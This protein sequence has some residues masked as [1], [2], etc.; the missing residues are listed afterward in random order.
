MTNSRGAVAYLRV[1][2]D[3]QG[4]SGLGLEAQ[5][6]AV[7]AWA[8]QR[9][10]AIVAE[11]VEV[12]SGRS[13]ERPQLD[14]ARAAAKAR[15]CTLVVAKL[16]RLSRDVD[17]IRAI[18]NGG[19]AAAFCDFPDIPEGPIGKFMLTMLASVAEFEAGLISSRTRAALAAAKARGQTLGNP[20]GADALRR[21]HRER[22][23]RG[24]AHDTRP[25]LEARQ[26]GAAEHAHSVAGDVAELRGQGVTSL[27][28]L[29][30]ALNDR[31]VAAPRG[32]QW[33]PTSVSRLLARIDAQ[34]AP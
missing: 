6:E 4:R 33:H 19:E 32:G 3:K 20:N 17:M 18:V 1:S 14:R 23:R 13:G 5:R 22:R 27:E 30:R 16:D 15:R 2:T 21:F 11:F 34:G 31:G 29:A 9:G 28:G 26:A 10:A 8:R 25:A 7:A 24:E 12:E